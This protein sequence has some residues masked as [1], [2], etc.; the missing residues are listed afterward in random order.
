MSILYGGP[1][2][3]QAYDGLDTEIKMNTSKKGIAIYTL[4]CGIYLFDG[5]C[6][7][8]GGWNCRH[9]ITPRP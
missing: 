2:D 6:T 1:F 5:Y 8:F 3:G 9:Q 4:I 7:W